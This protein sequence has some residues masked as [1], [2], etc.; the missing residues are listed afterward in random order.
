VVLIGKGLEFVS[1][2]SASPW[3]LFRSILFSWRQLCA[4]RA[5]LVFCLD[6]SRV[7]VSAGWFADKPGLLLRFP[8]SLQLSVLRTA[9]DLLFPQV[10]F[11]SRC[12]VLLRVLFIVNLQ[13]SDL[14]AD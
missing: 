5:L 12:L 3:L 8:F 9:A 1:V 4:D 11:F 7:L 10:L 2:F 13:G 14:R 6:Q